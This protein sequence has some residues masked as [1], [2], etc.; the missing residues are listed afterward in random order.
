MTYQ[1]AIL[2]FDDGIL[3]DDIVVGWELDLLYSCLH[4]GLILLLYEIVRSHDD[5]DKCLEDKNN[6]PGGESV[7]V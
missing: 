1:V 5:S 7:L 2:I 6:V 4:Y 3:D